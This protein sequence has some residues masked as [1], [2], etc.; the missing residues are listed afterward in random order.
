MDQEDQSSGKQSMDFS[1]PCDSIM[2]SRHLGDTIALHFRP[3]GHKWGWKRGIQEQELLAGQVEW[4]EK[5]PF[6]F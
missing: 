2:P 1:R 3:R 5:S 4:L 6:P